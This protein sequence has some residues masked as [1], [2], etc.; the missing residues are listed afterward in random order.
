MAEMNGE[1]YCELLKKENDFLKNALI[2]IQR[3]LAE[4]VTIN[5]D[6]LK[7]YDQ[8]QLELKSLVTDSQEIQTTSS[9]LQKTVTDSKTQAD[10]M[11]SLV[12]E[13]NDLLKSIVAISDQTNLLALNATIESARAGEAGKGFAVVANEVKELSKMTKKAAESITVSVSKIKSQ[14]NVV[15]K[16]MGESE[17]QCNTIK[18]ITEHFYSRLSTANEKNTSSVTKIAGTND[19]IFMS[20]AKLDHVIWKI[21]TYNSVVHNKPTFDFVDHN[22]CRLGKWYNEGDGKANFSSLPT[23]RNIEDPHFEV[24][25]CTKKIFESFGKPDSVHEISRLIEDMERSSD[26]IFSNLDRVLEE[27]NSRR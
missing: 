19:Q 13:I 3:N 17:G 24:H 26:L 8:I 2:N 1:Q 7:D 10:S 23:F 16:S 11:E 21:N 27:K 12:H 5:R 15:S 9:T 6:T 20:L 4:S 22:N 25:H 14:S 18:T